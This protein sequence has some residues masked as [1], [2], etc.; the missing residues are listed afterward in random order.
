MRA[1]VRIRGGMTNVGIHTPPMA[2][3]MT[4]DTAPKM[5]A[6]CAVRATLPMAKP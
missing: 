3:R 5:L 2:A 6:C 4:T 1:T